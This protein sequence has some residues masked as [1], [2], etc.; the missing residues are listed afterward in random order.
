MS[1][2]EEWSLALQP[3]GP[4]GAR[5]RG[6]W[7]EALFVLP[8]LLAAAVFVPVVRDAF[9]LRFAPALA[10]F[11]A[12][13]AY[14]GGL[15]ALEWR[16]SKAG[17]RTIT[18]LKLLGNAL[19][20]L[21]AASLISLSSEPGSSIFAGL[22]VFLA[23][24]QAHLMR[25]SFRHPSGLVGT[26]FAAVGGALLSP[27]AAHVAVFFIVGPAAII[28]SGVVGTA[29][30]AADLRVAESERLRAALQ[31]QILDEQRT[32]LDE[33]TQA[34]V[35]LLGYHHDV[36]GPLM[37]AQLQA[38]ALLDMARSGT[39]SLDELSPVVNDLQRALARIPTLLNEARSRGQGRIAAAL[40][41]VKLAPLLGGCVGVT[42]NR[43]V[44][45][46]FRVRCAEGQIA[47]VVGGPLALE[48][49]VDNL[50]VNACEGDGRRGARRVDV[51]VEESADGAFVSIQIADDGPGFRAEQLS[52][53]I[54]GFSTTKPTGTGL[55]LYTVERLARASGGALLRDNPPDGGARVTVRLPCAS[56]P[57][58]G[59]AEPSAG[60]L[61]A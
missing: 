47:R 59:M 2:Y 40:E 25:V 19:M 58:I 3:R 18:D 45:V 1:R 43:F 42:G 24:Y 55:G 41:H 13:Y 51:S 9:H 5:R 36:N 50:L 15:H 49:I 22:F 53:P 33:L 38:E 34:I 61:T 56:V 20:Q 32:R 23:S 48:R 6:V 11:L 28:A 10:G 44:A 35:D 29:T 21:Y 60:L 30:H 14:T 57:T 37:A 39:V 16:G 7:I 27:S 4:D 12:V 8:A 26:G 17:P 46:E 31:A 52:R 54:E